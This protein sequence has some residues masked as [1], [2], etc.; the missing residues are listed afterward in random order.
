[1]LLATA[2]VALPISRVA[3]GSCAAG[4]ASGLTLLPPRRPH[5][6][7]GGPPQTHLR[8]R[9]S[10]RRRRQPR[11]RRARSP[12]LRSRTCPIPQQDNPK[13]KAGSKQDVDAIGNRDV[14][15]GVNF[16]SLENEIALG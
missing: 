13:V 4:T 3:T 6:T 1:M 12:M 16:Y 14:G 9:R 10:N 5:P 2:V 7:T 11:R 15:K 8:M